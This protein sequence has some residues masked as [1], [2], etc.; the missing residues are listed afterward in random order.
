MKC[1][2]CKK[3]ITKKN[4]V[5]K[6]GYIRKTCRACVNKDQKERQRKKAEKLK[7]IRSYYS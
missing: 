4:R 2:K 6:I 7:I 1:N 3:E 5:T